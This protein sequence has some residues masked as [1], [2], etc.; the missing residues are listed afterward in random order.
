MQQLDQS[1]GNYAEGKK[2]VPKGYIVYDSIYLALLND[3][4]LETESRLVIEGGEKGNVQSYQRT[5]LTH[6]Q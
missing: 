5:R 1:G 2:P 3:K 4:T 6:S